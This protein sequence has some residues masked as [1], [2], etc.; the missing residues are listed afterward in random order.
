MIQRTLVSQEAAHRINKKE[1]SVSKEK[2]PTLWQRRPRPGFFRGLLLGFL[3]GVITLWCLTM[4]GCEP[5][6]KIQQ[7]KEDFDV[8]ITSHFFTYTALDFGDSIVK[9]AEAHSELV[10][11]EQ[12]LEVSTTITKAGLANL[13]IFSKTKTITYFGRGVFTVDLNRVTRD[14]IETDHE[15]KTVTIHIQKPK[16][17]YLNVDLEKTVFEDT[18]KGFLAFGD[19]ALTM[20]QQQEIQKSIEARMREMLAEEDVKAEAVNFARMKTWELFQPLVTSIDPEY[21]VVISF[22]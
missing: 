4:K 3:V 9:E 2:K 20:E 1:D 22:D 13:E 8:M 6:K 15:S 19:L 5:F 17:Q 18:E 21:K 11:M 14:K 12:P 16:L 10:V 7:A